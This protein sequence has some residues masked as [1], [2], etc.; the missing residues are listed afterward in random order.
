MS[1]SVLFGLKVGLQ[2]GLGDGIYGGI[3]GGIDAFDKGTDF[4]DGSTIVN[5]DGAFSCVETES[6]GIIDKFYDKCKSIVC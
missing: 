3:V 4:W 1:K 6:D 5:I 2:G